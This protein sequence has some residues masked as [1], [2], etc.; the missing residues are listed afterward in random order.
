MLALQHGP[1]DLTLVEIQSAK[2]NH[3]TETTSTLLAD[4]RR[5]RIIPIVRHI[6]AT[7]RLYPLNPQ[8]R[9]LD[10]ILDIG[11]FAPTSTRGIWLGLDASWG[12]EE[13]TAVSA[14]KD[15]RLQYQVIERATGHSFCLFSV[16]QIVNNGLFNLS[17][18]GTWPFHI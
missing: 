1:L 17:T 15:L 18:H 6:T 5:R 13:E 16:L 7:V 14:T 8:S 12:G 11:L 4:P 2:A 9:I 10:F 3:C